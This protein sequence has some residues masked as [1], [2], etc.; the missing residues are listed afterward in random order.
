[1]N[2]KLAVLVHSV[3]HVKVDIINQEIPVHYAILIVKLALV[4][5]IMNANLVNLGTNLGK[6]II[7]VVIPLAKDAM[8]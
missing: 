7:H 6:M 1:M 4:V 8:I 3:I 2:V 5:D